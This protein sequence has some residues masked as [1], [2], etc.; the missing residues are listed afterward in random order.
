MLKEN[1][2]ITCPVTFTLVKEN[3]E[4]DS[5]TVENVVTEQGLEHI[6]SSLIGSTTLVS[7]MALG[8]GT[9]AANPTQTSLA[10]EV[11]RRPFD[12]VATITTNSA[13]DTVQYTA[14]FGMGVATG[15]ISEAGLFN[16]ATAGTMTNR[17]AFGVINKEPNDTLTIEWRIV[18]S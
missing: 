7:H 9:T 5:F 13:N 12:S 8:S 16:D 18:I 15:Q 17:I 10:T 14:Q 4:I 11:E 1:I 3:G 6:A 2:K